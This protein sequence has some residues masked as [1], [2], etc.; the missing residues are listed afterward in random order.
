[1]LAIRKESP[2]DHP[3]VFEI[4]RQAFE[5]DTEAKLVESLRGGAAFDFVLGLAPMTM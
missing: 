4:N 2:E 3:A 1:M 5:I